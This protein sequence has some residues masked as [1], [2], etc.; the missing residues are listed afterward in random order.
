M[1][2]ATSNIYS[3][4]LSE[5]RYHLTLRL[6]HPHQSYSYTTHTLTNTTTPQA[7]SLTPNQSQH[8]IGLIFTTLSPNHPYTAE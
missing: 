8:S 3:T 6:Q 2:Q 4:N 1:I 7:I 5:T